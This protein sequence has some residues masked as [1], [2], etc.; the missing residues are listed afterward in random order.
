M[1]GE[2]ERLQE[3]VD[4]YD[5]IVFFGGAGVSTESG[6]PDFRSQD[7][8]YHQKYDYP[9][10]TILSHTFFMRKPEEFFKFYRDKML[11]DTAKPNAAHLKLA[12]LEQAGKLKAVITQNID[13]LHQMAGSK[14][15]LELHGS[16]YRLSLIHI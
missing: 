2:V 8:L 11:C 16:V 13:N 4:K 15:V 12:E 6:I 10:E 7:G 9:P 3:L 14:K 1:A 5:N